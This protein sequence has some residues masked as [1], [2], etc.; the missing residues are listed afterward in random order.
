[1]RLGGGERILDVG[2]GLG[3]LTRRLADVSGPDGLVLGIER[4]PVQLEAARRIRM[5]EDAAPLEFRAGD[6]ADLPL[7]VDE[8][9]SFDVAHARFVLEHLADPV[10]AVRQMVRAVRPGGRIVLEDDDHD[11][12]RL[13]PE[14]AQVLALWRAYIRAYEG[15]GLDPFVGR[16]LVGLL[17]EAGA[18]PVRN[19]WLFFGSCAGSATLQPMAANFAGVLDGAR[20][21]IVG[22]EDG[23]TDELVDAALAEFAAWARRPDA[24]LWYG[25][26]W[27]EGR[28]PR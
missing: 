24:T 9:G 16:R 14:P 25:T 19:H 1:M 11:V 6:A 23:W 12:L 27:A 5:D 3:Q 28:R 18:E 15:M 20:G 8:W 26:C 10:G 2:S 22:G 13:A 7:S 21:R 17:H 4:S